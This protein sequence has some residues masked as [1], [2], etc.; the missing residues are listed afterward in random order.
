MT[1]YAKIQFIAYVLNTLPLP[2]AADPPANPRYPGLDDAQADI[3]ARCALVGRAIQAAADAKSIGSKDTLKIFMIPEFAL[4]GTLGAY[5]MDGVGSAVAGLKALVTDKRFADW[6]FVFGSIVGSSLPE[7]E[8]DPKVDVYNFTLVQRGGANPGDGD[9]HVVMKEF[10][11]SIDFIQDATVPPAE[12][13]D[14]QVVPGL[15]LVPPGMLLDSAVRYMEAGAVGMGRENQLA[16]YDGAGIFDCAGLRFGIEICL[17]HAE[18]RLVESPQIPGDTAVQVQLVPSCGMRIVDDALVPDA[19]AWAFGCDGAGMGATVKQTKASS[20]APRSQVIAVGADDLAVPVGANPAVVPVDRLFAG[21]LPAYLGAGQG[22][23]APGA[24]S[25]A[26]NVVVYDPVPVP[27]Q[28]TVPG[29]VKTLVWNND[30]Y[31]IEFGLMYEADG[32]Y[33]AA[34]V[35]VTNPDSDLNGLAHLLPVT[36][37]HTDGRGTSRSIRFRVTGG[38]DDYDA[39]IECDS[40]LEDFPFSGLVVE[41][42]RKSG[43]REP[44]TIW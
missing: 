42:D 27:P 22:V 38:G 25:A 9:S 28:Q 8:D 20:A 36:L 30:K 37:A 39:G 1:A 23:R 6:V 35:R 41:F 18:G 7:D 31:M 10:K 33:S 32:S 24:G 44:R 13:P 3:A 12:D 21:G 5:D 15:P 11:S 26:G 19:G 34:S 14:F 16:N 4:R 2:A 40:S 17:D 29:S 43:T